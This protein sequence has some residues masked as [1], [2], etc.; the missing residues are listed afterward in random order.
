MADRQWLG[1]AIAAAMLWAPSAQA[2]V[3]AAGDAVGRPG[4][5][6]EI[7]VILDSGGERV[8]GTQNDL[9]VSPPLHLDGGDPCTVNP[10]IGKAGSF[11]IASCDGNPICER[12]RAIVLAFDNVDVIADGSVLYRCRVGIDSDAAGGVYPLPV[13]N[14]GSSDPEGRALPTD[15]FAGRVVVGETPGAVV[16]VDDAV[17]PIGAF[18]PIRVRLTGFATV[19]AVS[20][21]IT[22]SEAVRIT[23]DVEDQPS[24]RSSLPG[25]TARFDFLPLGCAIVRDECTAMRASITAPAPLPFGEPLYECTV[26][27]APVIEP[28]SYVIDCPAASATDESGAPVLAACQSGTAQVLDDDLSPTVEP[29]PSA[30]AATP[31]FT[32][33]VRATAT[34]TLV[35]GANDDDGCQVGP[36]GT[37]TLLPLLGPALL[38]ARR[39][40]SGTSEQRASARHR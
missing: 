27:P 34:P 9:E 26:F 22:L 4:D 35:A 38:L 16:Q 11:A 36:G 6:V 13:T 37:G 33:A 5:I 30:V 21:V 29:T 10:S 18:T 20:N 3:L 28:G 12:L 2:V 32:A 31:T 14:S 24:C 39:R 7:A 19:T 23:V 15:G 8:A 17:L 40:R 25:V 1:A